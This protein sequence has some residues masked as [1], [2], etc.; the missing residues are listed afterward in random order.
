MCE[1][2]GKNGKNKDEKLKK[3]TDIYKYNYLNICKLIIFVYLSI[4]LAFLYITYN[5]SNKIIL[6][7][8]ADQK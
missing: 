3:D 5:S 4:H 7:I 6:S 1:G 8:L 2:C